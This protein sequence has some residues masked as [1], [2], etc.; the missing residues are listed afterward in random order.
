[1]VVSHFLHWISTARV[2]ERAAAAAALARAY[3]DAELP[4][5]ERCAAEAALTLLLDDASSK[6]RQAMA[7]ALS[8]SHHAPVQIIAA[9]AADQPE[10]AGPI[11]ARSPLLTDADLIDR[12]AAG[13]E[14]THLLIADRPVLSMAVSAAVAEIAGPHACITLLGNSGAAVASLSFRRMAERHGHVATLREV[15]IADARLPA[16]CRHMLLT[17]LGEALTGS[18]LVLALMGRARADRVM[19]DACVKAS[20]TLIENTQAG[21]HP[22]LIEHLRLRGDLTASFLIRT[23]AHGK[24]DFF[25]S[26]LMALTGYSGERVRSLLA[27]GHDT[28]LLAL[29]AA[30][31]LAKATHAIIVRA[32]KVWREVANGKRVAGVQEVSWLMLK[33][34]GGQGAQGDLAT[35]VKSIHLDALRQNARGH[36]LAI[37]A[38]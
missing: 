5:E 13:G 35:L 17:K 10:V 32:L 4:F 31:G 20:V 14:A 11:L 2:A 21:E 38:A 34:L 6:V 36:A 22:A 33:E 7:E 24:V 23:V 12:V 30:A 26:A 29:F 16:D 28:A 3:I 18:P 8:L 37:A 19:R 9:L 25:G 15:L 1:M 27:S